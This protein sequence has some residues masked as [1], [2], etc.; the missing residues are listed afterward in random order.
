MDTEICKAWIDF[1]GTVVGAFIVVVAGGY[2]SRRYSR[3]RD[4]QDKESQWRSHAIELTKLDLERKMKAPGSASEPLR[5]SI[6]D[7]LANYRDLSELGSRSPAELY[8]TILDKRIAKKPDPPAP[9]T[10]ASETGVGG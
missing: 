10:T 5:P 3:E 7:F 2:I 6:L 1:A 4:R 8:Q 9:P